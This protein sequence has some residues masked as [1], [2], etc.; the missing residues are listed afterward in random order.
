MSS[1]GLLGMF[2]SRT[3]SLG[4]AATYLEGLVTALSGRLPLTVFSQREPLPKEPGVVP[5]WEPGWGFA[6]SVERALSTHPVRLLHIQ[7]EPFLYGKG[8]GAI[9]SLDLPRRVRRQGIEC[10]VTLHGVPFPSLMRSRSPAEVLI[11]ALAVPYLAGIARSARWVRR[12]IVHE[13]AQAETLTRFAMI[14]EAL[15]TSIPHGVDEVTSVAELP[16]SPLTV[17]TFGYLTP[18]KDPGYVIEE[19]V[20]LRKYR[21]EARLLFSLS[22]HPRR[23]LGRRYR[24]IM[25][26]AQEV[27]G[28]EVFGHIPQEQLADFLRRCHIVV[29]PHRYAVAASGVVAKALGQGVPVLVPAGSGSIADLPGW[30]FRHEPG[31]LSSVLLHQADHL[32][33]MRAEGL[34]LATERSWD[35]VADRHMQLYFSSE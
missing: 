26:R 2:P 8:A 30:S 1:V 9:L 4:G 31:S 14:P 29:A 7:H 13:A 10:I 19:F 20:R 22:R 18:Y 33:E 23:N 3:E 6:Q 16:S 34:R 12:F 11:R 35:F 28:I 25:R 24:R 21:P 5:A 15:V 32:P 17:G 27:K